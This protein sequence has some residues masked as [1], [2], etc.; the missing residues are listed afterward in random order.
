M[1]KEKKTANKTVDCKAGKHEAYKL[2]NEDE[3]HAAAPLTTT[4]IA[5]KGR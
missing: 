5:Y 3:F 4:L 1:I 2:Q